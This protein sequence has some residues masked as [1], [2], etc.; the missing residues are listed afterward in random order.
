MK[1]IFSNNDW[2]ADLNGYVRDNIKAHKIVTPPQKISGLKTD[3]RF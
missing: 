2:I 3:Q 1:R